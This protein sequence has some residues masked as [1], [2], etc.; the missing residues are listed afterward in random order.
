MRGSLFPASV[1]AGGH[2][3]HPCYNKRNKVERRPLS[4]AFA[5]RLRFRDNPRTTLA[6]CVRNVQ[7]LFEFSNYFFLFFFFGMHCQSKRRKDS[8]LF[9]CSLTT[10]TQRNEQTGNCESKVR[11]IGIE[12]EDDIRPDNARQDRPSGTIGLGT[13][14]FIELTFIKDLS[15]ERR[16]ESPG[17]FW[18]GP[19]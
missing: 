12:G 8:S 10:T 18:P 9:A 13:S 6:T 3:F 16:L 19:K 17:L 11:K 5:T 14:T 2:H 7:L 1:F 15:R 4:R